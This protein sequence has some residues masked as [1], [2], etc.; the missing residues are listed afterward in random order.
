MGKATAKNTVVNIA[1]SDKINVFA[2]FCRNLQTNRSAIANLGL[3]SLRFPCVVIL[4]CEAAHEF[5][6]SYSQ[7]S[8]MENLL[9][10]VTF[11]PSLPKSALN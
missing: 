1:K 2:V 8:R 5:V 4:E 3:L 6:Y 7:N 11:F 10:P 9:L